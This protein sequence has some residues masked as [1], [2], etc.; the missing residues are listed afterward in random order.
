[1]HPVLF[2][3]GAVVIPSYGAL[4]A[5]GV[6]VALTAALYTSRRLGL[7]PNKI[8][9]L[10]VIVLFTSLAGSRLLLVLANWSLLRHH[11]LWVLSLAMVH[12]PLL[13]AIGTLLA[14][15][16]AVLYA[17]WQRLSLRTTAD[18]LA[19]PL[20][21]GLALEQF[22]ALLSGAGYGTGTHVPW[23]VT[24][25]DPL[26]ARWSDAPLGI[27]VHPVQAY[28][29][30]CF[31]LIA[32]LLLFLSPR[33]TQNGDLAGIF[34][35]ASGVVLFITEFWRDPIGRGAIPGGFLKAP[36]LAGIIAVLGGAFLLL[37]RESHHI[38]EAESTP[39]ARAQHAPPDAQGPSHACAAHH[40]RSSRSRR[41]AARALHCHAT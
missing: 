38:A 20:A 28:A 22:G 34:L 26:A 27:P 35:M 16:V 8:W 40:R 4:A 12:H 32:A 31:L 19:A 18:A 30:I 41:P 14:T 2:H 36:Q 39:S 10:C 15:V 29:G 21:L 6:L 33:R 24:Y 9:N 37:E 23:A 11:P 1:V 3:I 5:L 17:T 13:A 7:D 25:T